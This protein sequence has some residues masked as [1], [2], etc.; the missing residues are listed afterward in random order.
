[1]SLEFRELLKKIASGKHTGQNLTRIEAERATYLM[2]IGEAT[3]A[4]MGA[5]MIAHRIKRPT[6]EELAGMLDA[7]EQLGPQLTPP[8]LTPKEPVIILGNPYDGRSRTF[9]L[10]PLIAL[11]LTHFGIPVIMHGGGRIPTKEGLPLTDIWDAL[12]IDWRQFN[13]IQ[14]QEIFA[15][16][17]LGFIYLDRLFPQ[18]YQLI[19]YRREIGKRSPFST[20]ELVW[21]PYR[22]KAHVITG[23]VHPPT[24]TLFKETI[25]LRK[26]SC[27]NPILTTIKGL[28]GSCDLPRDRTAIISQIN[29]LSP[30]QESE[31]LL[32]HSRDYGLGGKEISLPSDEQILPELESV[33]RGERSQL[34]LALIWNAGFYLWHCG[35]SSDL[36]S[37]INLAENCLT[38]C[39]ILPHL[40]EIR[41]QIREIKS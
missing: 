38:R 14:I 29:L 6:S 34:M 15:K 37:G 27:S 11:I 21:N 16:T 19:P 3:P 22:G 4:Q 18:A 32:L 35:V 24:E 12:G 5:F 2:L 1:M 39:E 7:Y 23:Y 9:P 41:H 36:A 30:S 26:T 8:Q 40:N 17:Q 25:I 28:E 33:L 13:L 31:R 20:L 10:S